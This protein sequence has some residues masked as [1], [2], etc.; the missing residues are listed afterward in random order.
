MDTKE[1]K[2]TLHILLVED[3]ELNQ[4]FAM[5]VL[6]R[7]GH[8]YELAEN[9]AIGFQKYLNG[10]FDLI[11]MDIQMPEM[12]GIEATIAIREHERKNNIKPI[13]IIAVTAFAMEHDRINCME[14]GMNE[15]LT[16]PYKPQDMWA[17]IEKVLE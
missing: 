1:N 3:N 17:K 7:L 8:T 10:K 6:K 2:K 9:G 5:A 4:K 13:P 14:A 16:K 12:N 11:L 15:F